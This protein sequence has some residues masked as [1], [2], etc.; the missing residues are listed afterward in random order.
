MIK[1]LIKVVCMFFTVLCPAA[2]EAAHQKITQVLGI[3]G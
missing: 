3:R 1:R 2:A